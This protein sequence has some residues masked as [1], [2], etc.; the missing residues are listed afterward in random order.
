[1]IGARIAGLTAYVY[2]FDGTEWIEEA[3]LTPL[4]FASSDAVG[5]PVSVSGDAVVIGTN[6]DGSAYVY[7]FDGT[8]WLEEARLAA[9]DATYGDCFGA[10]VFIS[11]DVAVV[12][13][14][15]VGLECSPLPGSI[16]SAAYIFRFDGE[17]WNEEARLTASDTA[18]GSLFNFFGGS[19]SIHDDV[20]L[21]GAGSEGAYLYRFDGSTWVE[22]S[23]LIPSDVS[24]SFGISAVSISGDVAVIGGVLASAVG[25]DPGSASSAAYV[26]RFDGTNW[27][28]QAKL[29]GSDP[30]DGVNS[31]GESDYFGN[32]VSV[33]GDVL[34]IGA[35]NDGN[36]GQRFSL[37]GSGAAYVFSVA[38]DC[39]SPTLKSTRRSWTTNGSATS[40]G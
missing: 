22:E 11:G 36:T 19:V 15:S 10:S 3:M 6:G 37:D 29:T 24:G 39:P 20:T 1:V 34:V 27:I 2:R 32:S 26:Y 25:G 9:S 31:L 17:D 21:I 35:E 30:A 33:S 13:A 38:P 12:G 18:E 8:N 40:S 5:P 16:T 4:D 14:P 23:K 7:R 28:E